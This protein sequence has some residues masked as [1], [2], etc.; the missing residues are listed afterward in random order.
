ME[1]VFGARPF[2]MWWGDQGDRT[3]I[4]GRAGDGK[5]PYAIETL[6]PCGYS[7]P[8]SFLFV[9]Q[10]ASDSMAFVP[11]LAIVIF[12]IIKPYR[13]PNACR[14]FSPA[15]VQ[16][17]LFLLAICSSCMAHGDGFHIYVEVI[18]CIYNRC[19]YVGE[20]SL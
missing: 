16:P 7:R 14:T 4:D 17:P 12:F 10:N 2:S 19:Q 1:A 13:M 6:E 5:T 15:C 11:G 3:Q 9:I 8:V 18:L 20:C